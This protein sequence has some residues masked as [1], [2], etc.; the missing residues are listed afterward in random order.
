MF[1]F[2]YRL[3]THFCVSDS[4]TPLKRNAPRDEELLLPNKKFRDS[5]E[6]RVSF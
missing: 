1:T 4:P 2:T 6:V 5:T 3:P